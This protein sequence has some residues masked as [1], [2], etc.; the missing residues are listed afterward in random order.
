[1]YQ[2]CIILTAALLLLTIPL[3]LAEEQE[4]GRFPDKMVVTVLDEEGKPITHANG[5]RHFGQYTNFTVNE[6]GIFEIPITPDQWQRVP[7]LSFEVKTEGYGTFLAVFD[8]EPIIPDTF[9]VVLKPAQKIGGL[10]VDDEGKPVEGVEVSLRVH[11]DNNFNAPRGLIVSFEVKTDANGRWSLFHLPVAERFPHLLLRKEGYLQTNIGDIPATRLNPDAAGQFNEKVVIER[12][13]VCTGRVVDEAG[14]P[15]EGVSLRLGRGWGGDPTITTDKD[16]V[17]RFENRSLTDRDLLTAYVSG[18]APQMLFVEVHSV[19]EP[20]KVVMKPGRTVTFVVT[21]S[22]G[23]PLNDVAFSVAS[24]DGFPGRRGHQADLP[25]L[26][27]NNKSGEDG[28]FVWN[29]APD[30]LCE[31]SCWLRG[32]VRAQLHIEPGQDTFALT[33]HRSL[34]KLN[35]VDDETGELIPA[36]I[37]T[38]KYYTNPEDE[39]PRSWTH[40]EGGAG[41]TKEMHLDGSDTNAWQFDIQAPGYE[42]TSSRRV[43][44]GEEDVVLEVRMKKAA[45]ATVIPAPDQ[46]RG[47]APAGIQTEDVNPVSLDPRLRGGDGK[48]E[49]PLF[50]LS[51]GVILTPDGENAANATVQIAVKDSLCGPSAAPI[52]ADSEGK[53]VLTNATHRSIGPQ[54]FVVHISHPSGAIILNG[55]DFRANHDR[56]ANAD[57]EP[58]RLTKWGRIEGTL[59]AGDR[60]LEGADLHI[61]WVKP[62][63]LPVGVSPWRGA[64]TKKDGRFVIEEVMPGTINVLRLVHAGG[65]GSSWSSYYG[66]I[67]VKPGETTVCVIGGTGRAV[68]GR[69]MVPANISFMQYT[70]RIVPKPDDLADL[71]TPTIPREYLPQPDDDPETC[72]LRLLAWYQTDEGKEYQ[73]QSE[74]NS[75]A[76]RNLRFFALNRDGTFRFDDLPAGDYA[77][78]ISETVNCG[79][80]T[81]VGDWHLQTVF[82]VAEQ[83]GALPIDLGELPLVRNPQ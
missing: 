26:Q 81:E 29:D 72:N 20:I 79:L 64:R 83:G 63:D 54:E 36:F 34:V 69:A 40:P 53:F 11:P 68:V 73:R 12:G 44:R 14:A 37:V 2:S 45:E 82:T 56:E 23:Q 49:T 35:V 58:I 30:S 67:E 31:I 71:K 24:I 55:K 75:R 39:R 33:L 62:D 32:Y 47:Q 78:V 5:W 3:T 10:V 43:V 38:T 21:D 28:R 22:A 57:A 8:Y 46:G 27:E 9:T 50:P 18:K 1:M 70:A 74:R 4:R 65:L 66:T 76:V 60:K 25:F 16:G 42:T 15:I 48:A 80:G 52:Q 51:G 41:G 17:F 61:R 6:H 19:E 59:Q 77:L 13:Y 7:S